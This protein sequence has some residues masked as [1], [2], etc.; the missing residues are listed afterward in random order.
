MFSVYVIRNV[1]NGKGYVSIT[2]KPLE[3]RMAEHIR[4]ALEK[5]RF[6]ANGLRYATAL[7]EFRLLAEQG[8]ANA[9]YNLGTMYDNGEG[10]REDDEEAAKWYRKA[11]E[12]G[13]ATALAALETGRNSISIEIDP[14][15]VDLIEKRLS[16]DTPLIGQIEIIRRQLEENPAPA[17]AMG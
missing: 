5:K 14:K 15:Y 4:D 17:K 12:Q 11:A 1:I 8:D 16:A 6:S 7:R 9:Q 13:D 2:L 10:V 3:Q